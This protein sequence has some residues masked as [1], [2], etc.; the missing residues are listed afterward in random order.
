MWKPKKF[1]QYNLGDMLWFGLVLMVLM[2]C[3]MSSCKTVE[4]KPDDVEKLRRYDL[5]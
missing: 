4:T 3:F 5:P 2:S 1:D